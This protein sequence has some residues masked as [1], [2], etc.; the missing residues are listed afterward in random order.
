MKLRFFIDALH[1]PQ[2]INDRRNAAVDT[3]GFQ[4]APIQRVKI[5]LFGM[6]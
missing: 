4:V 2:E 1:L 6:Q 5:D 3:D